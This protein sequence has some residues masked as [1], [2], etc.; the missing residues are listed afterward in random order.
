M[1]YKKYKNVVICAVPGNDELDMEEIENIVRHT[2]NTWQHDRPVSE[3][4][5]NTIQG[6]RAELAIEHIL[7][8]NSAVRYLSYDKLRKDNFNKH[9]PFD[10]VIYHSGVR[11]SV[12]TEAIERI[13]GDVSNSA[14]ESGIITTETRE[15][16][17]DKG[18]FTVEIKSS[19]LQDP[20]D[21][22]NM[23]HKSKE[24]RT[25]ED[26]DAL[27]EYIKNFYDYFVYPHYCRD[28]PEITS[29][30]EY[31]TYVRKT[32]PEIVSGTDKAKFLQNLMKIEFMNTCDVYT[33][34]F[35]DVL[36]D[37]III[38]GY[39]I[40]TRFFEE[41][42][43][44]KMPSVKSKN[45]IYYMYHM[46]LGSGI[47]EIEED[48]ELK[49]WNGDNERA[50]LL[51]MQLPPCPACANQLKLVETI[52]NSDCRKHKFL[53]LCE[54]CKTDKWFEMNQ[55]HQRNMKAR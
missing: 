49:Q 34:V 20:R 21:Y 10:G 19:L 36:S 38:P 48:T 27:C 28:H 32:H 47:L 2:H 23:L 37:E 50:G 22:R 52:K 44:M 11:E 18:I 9:A 4:R 43:I 16:L 25:E 41:P 40:K 24:Q 14:G 39:V 5:E 51:G 55:I 53:Y 42:R 12:L 46:N 31:T 33:R 6:K 3:I 54:T 1:E 35:F 7:E 8:E 26:Y 29:F 30:Y 17:E 13:N 15:F 45:A